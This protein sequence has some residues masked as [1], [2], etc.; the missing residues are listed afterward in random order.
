MKLPNYYSFMLHPKGFLALIFSLG[1]AVLVACSS[2]LGENFSRDPVEVGAFSEVQENI[3]TGL[4]QKYVDSDKQ[5]R[6]QAWKTSSQD[7]A[8]LKSILSAIAKADTDAMSPSEKKSF[9]INAY[10]AMTIDLILSHFDETL[11]SDSSPYPTQRSIRNIGNQDSKVWDVYTWK[12]GGQELSLNDVEHKI[13]RPMGD[14][15]IHFAVVCASKGCPPILNRA[16]SGVDLDQTLDQLADDFVNSGKNTKFNAAR[17]EIKTSHILDWF[18]EDFV[19][20]FGSVNSF[21]AKYVTLLPADQVQGMRIRYEPY[22]WLL[23]E[24]QTPLNDD[25]VEN[26]PPGSGSETPPCE[27]PPGSG[28]ENPCPPPSPPGSGTEDPPGSGTESGK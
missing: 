19:K 3:Y 18:S 9:L 21:F 16:F 6:Y 17:N 23:N 12:V 26:P 2:D 5:I 8:A 7:V 24:S 10:N 27:T 11:G 22:D 13:L 25:P 20:H 15:R 1:T 28:T 4:L 14:S